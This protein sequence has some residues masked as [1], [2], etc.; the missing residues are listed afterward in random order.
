MTA[1]VAPDRCPGTL[2]RSAEN[3]GLGEASFRRLLI[4]WVHVLGGLGQ[5]SDHR[6][7][8]DTPVRRDFVLGDEVTRPGLHRTK[9]TALDTWDLDE[10]RDGIASHPEVMLERGARGICSN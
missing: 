7:D 10:A 2:T 8:I 3:E 6:V 5:R 9:R 1:A 4:L